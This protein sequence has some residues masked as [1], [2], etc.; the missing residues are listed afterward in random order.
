MDTQTLVALVENLL[1]QPYE[2]RLQANLRYVLEGLEAVHA[3]HRA[4]RSLPQEEQS[5]QDFLQHL[6]SL[7]QGL[8]GLDAALSARDEVQRQQ[9]LE[10]VREAA[11]GF[12]GLA[13]RLENDGEVFHETL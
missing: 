11:A 10:L 2:A 1:S 12:Q 5:R 9:A 7:Y 6:G 8:Q 4:P 3:R 13:E